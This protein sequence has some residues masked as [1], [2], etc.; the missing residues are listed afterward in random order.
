MAK[1]VGAWRT[2]KVTPHIAVNGAIGPTGKRREAALDRR[3]TRHPGSTVSQRIR[4]RIE[5]VFGWIK[6]QAGHDQVNVRGRAKAEAVF[7][8]AAAACNLPRIPKPLEGS[9][10]PADEPDQDASGPANRVRRARTALENPLPH[11][12]QPR[13]RCKSLLL[14]QPAG[15]RSGFSADAGPS[16][17]L[18]FPNSLN[19]KAKADQYDK[20]RQSGVERYKAMLAAGPDSSLAFAGNPRR[21]RASHRSEAPRNAEN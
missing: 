7:T 18:L 15:A 8:F 2:R 4:K 3:T 6:A 5:G 20:R 12:P 10:P 19:E 21:P 14:Q 17:L 1:F 13:M 9:A 16:A 11:Q